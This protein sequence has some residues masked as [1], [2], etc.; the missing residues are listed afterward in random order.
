[1]AKT[2]AAD[3]VPFLG[4]GNLLY[5]HIGILRMWEPIP[6]LEQQTATGNPPK[7]LCYTIVNIILERL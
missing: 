3:A 5:A 4:C 6:I 7:H 1:M 2:T